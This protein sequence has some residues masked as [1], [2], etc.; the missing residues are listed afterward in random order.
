LWKR[1]DIAQLLR[2][3]D[4]SYFILRQKEAHFRRVRPPQAKLAPPLH[5]DGAGRQ[6]YGATMAAA[7]NALTA[8]CAW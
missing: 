8:G 2:I 5:K 6:R 1:N 4:N 3:Y 7:G